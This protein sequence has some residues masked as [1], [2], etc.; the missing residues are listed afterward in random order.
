MRRAPNEMT[1][2]SPAARL[3]RAALVAMP[4]AWQSRPRSAVSYSAHSTYVPS[5]TSTGSCGP[6]TVP[7]SIAH[8]ST[9]SPSSSAA[10]SS[11]PARM[12]KL[13]SA[14]GKLFSRISALTRLVRRLAL[15]IWMVRWK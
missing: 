10:A 3:Q 8:T 7:S 4:E 12:P 15:R 14:W 5:M 13:Q 1:A 2:R 11:I 9:G 6:K